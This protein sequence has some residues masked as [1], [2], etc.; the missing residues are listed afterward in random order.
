MGACAAQTNFGCAI[1]PAKPIGKFIVDFYAPRASLVIELD[2]GQHFEPEQRHYDQRRS[3]FL[4]QQGLTVLRFT[5]LDVLKNLEGVME[6]IFREVQG[7]QVCFENLPC[8]PLKKGG[9]DGM[10]HLLPTIEKKREE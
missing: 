5:N 10:A 3:V 6:I 2:G 9:K 7:K 1:L 4:E 8:P